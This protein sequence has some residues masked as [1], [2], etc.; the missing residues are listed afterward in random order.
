M[1]VWLPLLLLVLLVPVAGL[2]FVFRLS[3]PFK[4][5]EFFAGAL[6]LGFGFPSVG[7]AE[8][9]LRLR[10][11]SM[12]PEDLCLANNDSG[13]FGSGLVSS[14]VGFDGAGSGEEEWDLWVDFCFFTSSR[15]RSRSSWAV[16]DSMDALG[17]KTIALVKR[18]RRSR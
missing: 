10:H 3:S 7:F 15:T 18:R 5:D 9:E 13:F 16:T 12:G 4:F 6:G 2:S 8:M 14:D 1:I 11:T 17:K